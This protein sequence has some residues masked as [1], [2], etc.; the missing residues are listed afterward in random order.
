MGRY[1]RDDAGCRARHWP[2][3]SLPGFFIATG[4]SGHGFGIGPGVGKV[5]A[6]LLT[7]TNSGIDIRPFRLSRFFDGSPIRMGP[8]L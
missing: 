6:G 1:D 2:E 3:E 7:G 4:L 5:A 8:A